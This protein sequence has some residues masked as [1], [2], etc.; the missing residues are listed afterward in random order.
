MMRRRSGSKSEAG[1]D[2]LMESDLEAGSDDML[3]SPMQWQGLGLSSDGLSLDSGI[4]T[5]NTHSTDGGVAPVVP[6]LLRRGTM[7]TKVTRKKRKSLKFMLDAG[8]GKVF[9]NPNNISKRFYIDD[10]QEIRLGRDARNY[11]EEFN[12]QDNFETR[13]FTI[14]YADHDRAKG[15]PLK[16]MHLIAPNQEIFELWTSTLGS[17][18]KYRHQLMAGLIGQDEKSLQS[19]WEREMT[20][21]FGGAPH[22]AEEEYLDLQGVENLCRSLH[23]WCSKN[24]L[25]A[26]FE[27]ADADGTKTLSYTEFKDF[28][29]RLKQRGDIKDIY[30]SLTREDPDGLGLGNFLNFL[31]D[32]QRVDVAQCRSHWV[33]VFSKFLPKI[34]SQNPILPEV[35]DLSISRMDL[36]GFSTFMSSKYNNVL[37]AKPPTTRLEQPLNEYFIASSHNTYL[38]GRQFNDDSSVEPYIRALQKGCRCV[39]I[40]CWDGENG[41]PVVK[42]GHSL[43]TSI[44]FSDV[45]SIIGKPEYSFS[46]SPYP[47]IL[48]L[49]VHCCPEQQQIM[50]DIMLDKLT[51]W[52]ICEPLITN[53][54][55]LPSPED[56]KHKILVKVK[57][58]AKPDKVSD[59]PAK[60][61][62]RSLSSP[63][64]RPQGLDNYTIPN[65]VP[66]SSPPSTSPPDSTTPWLIGRGSMTT[67]SMSSADDSD[68]AQ[69]NSPRPKRSA[70]KPKTKII[71]SLGN[72]GVYTQGIKYNKSFISSES[73]TLNHVFSIAESHFIKI[74]SKPEDKEQLERHNMRHLMRVYPAAWRWT[75]SNP[76]PLVVWRR[77]VQMVA[78]NWQTYDLPMQMNDAMFASGQDQYGYVLKPRELRQ[79]SSLEESDVEPIMPGISKPQ[80]KFIKFSVKIISAQQLP[81]PWRMGADKILDPYIEIEMFS[82]EDKGKGLAAGEGGQDAS[83]RNGISGIGAPHRRRSRVVQANGFNPIFD[84]EFKLS[85]STK[86][87]E[88]VFVRWSVWNSLDGNGYNNNPSLDPLATFTAKLST[89]QEGYRHLPLFDHNGDQFLFS[90]LFCKIK[91]ED[92]LPIQGEEPAAEK[93]GRF[94]SFLGRTASVDKK[95]NGSRVER[96]T[97]RVFESRSSSGVERKNSAN[98]MSPVQANGGERP[99]RNRPEPRS[100]TGSD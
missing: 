68:A 12:V 49:E 78:L 57:A 52:L 82:A 35:P 76:D 83:P 10:I 38:V 6:D 37:A 24:V 100:P 7:L 31:E 23:I 30:K 39:E 2:G 1:T 33:K 97:S 44:S 3:Q 14:I 28:V 50:V 73:Q 92:P 29:R 4:A 34:D 47:L 42:H 53:S 84:E 93:P 41:R 86:Y 70:S 13:F 94:R 43:T 60:T 95:N 72:L 85:L 36:A 64:S 48:S 54:F 17:L 9:W 45:I 98:G 19:H 40:D 27:K 96:K 67:T 81:R 22:A 16:A 32:Q 65:G 26:Q 25:R 99:F 69:G 87:P 90:T 62:E 89:L 80:S 11:R 74:C 20:R 15:K 18:S 5:P 91:K 56:L 51:P 58:G 46:S 75:S 59:T 55:S 63:Y 8:S 61:R 71:S 21:I 79:S 88:L 66:L 77:G